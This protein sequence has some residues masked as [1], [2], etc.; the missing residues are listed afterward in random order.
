[1]VNLTATWC[2]AVVRYVAQTSTHILF[3][4]VHGGYVYRCTKEQWDSGVLTQVEG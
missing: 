2:G 1:M 3:D 4:H